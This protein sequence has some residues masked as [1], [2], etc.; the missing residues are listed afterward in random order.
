MALSDVDRA[1]P[2]AKAAEMQGES[3]SGGSSPH[4]ARWTE[5]KRREASER[6]K[7]GHAAGTAPKGRG[8]H[9]AKPVPVVEP[10]TEEEER[11]IGLMIGS[12]WNLG[13]GMMKLAAMDKQDEHTM[14]RAAAPV[15]RKYLPMLGDWSLEVTLLM[16]TA[17]MVTAKRAQWKKEHPEDETIPDLEIL[18]PNHSTLGAVPS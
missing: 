18:G 10:I 17:M 6:M 15:I 3:P 11:M 4:K 12:L 1:D 13:G 2:V 8:T 7:A 9:K 5:E 16:V 14:G